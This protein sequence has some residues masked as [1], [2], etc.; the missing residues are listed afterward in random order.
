MEMEVVYKRPQLQSRIHPGSSVFKKPVVVCS[1]I[2]ILTIKN[3]LNKVDLLHLI[4][5]EIIQLG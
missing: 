1:P 3:I 5:I 2:G 4:T